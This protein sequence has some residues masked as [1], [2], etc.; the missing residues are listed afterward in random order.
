M[1]IKEYKESE[2]NIA[3]LNLL[4]TFCD[5]LQDAMPNDIVNKMQDLIDLM[6]SKCEYNYEDADEETNE[7]YRRIVYK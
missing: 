1:I 6:E 7:L 2:C 4:Y 3:L 5:H